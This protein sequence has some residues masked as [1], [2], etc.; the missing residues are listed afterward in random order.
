MEL[1]ADSSTRYAK[2]RIAE[3]EKGIFQK[4]PKVPGQ[5]PLIVFLEAELRKAHEH[6]IASAS[7]IE[8][9]AQEGHGAG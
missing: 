6:G 1:N 5:D 3:F 2:N 7:I 9:K 4:L 8:S